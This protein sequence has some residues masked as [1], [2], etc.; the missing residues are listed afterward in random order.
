MASRR[1]SPYVY[2]TWLSKLLVGDQVCEWAAWFRAHY[3]R[4][5]KAPSSFDSAGWKMAHTAL[6]D[7][8]Y[9]QL[10]GAGQSV[11]MEGQNWFRLEGKCATLGGKPDLIGLN[12]KGQSAK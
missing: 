6:L 5:E 3:E 12:G 10:I 7:R 8:K 11:T 1:S 4:Y 2:A 9:R